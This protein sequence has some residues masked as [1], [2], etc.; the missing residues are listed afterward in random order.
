MHGSNGCGNTE[1][2]KTNSEDCGKS[3]QNTTKPKG[4]YASFLLI[5][6]AVAIGIIMI[7]WYMVVS[8]QVKQQ[9]ENS[10]IVK[11]AKF[12]RIPVAKV[13]KA[14]V[15][16]SDYVKDKNTLA[17]F[18]NNSPEALPP[19]VGTQLS[20]MVISRLVATK[21]IYQIAQDNAITVSEEEKEEKRKEVFA[22]F[23]S[24]EEAKK[25]VQEKY[26]ISF[27]TYFAD[28]VTP[29]ILE[30]KIRLAI[31]D[32]S[33]SV[34]EQFAQ[35]QRKAR[36]ILFRVN[37]E[38]TDDQA[39]TQAEQVQKKLADGEDFAELAKEF[40]GDSTKENGG[41]LGWFGRGTMVPEFE[42][43][44][45]ALEP[46]QVSEDLVKTQFGY[47]IVKLDDTRSIQDFAAYMESQ[48]ES[49]DIQFLV[50]INN[51]FNQVE[52]GAVINEGE[53]VQS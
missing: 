46:G 14:S 34:D 24:E 37:E 12:F 19:L 45:F 15:L 53:E 35:E 40:G 9:S 31:E 27:E 20:D 47:H 2:C 1:S 13:N 10:S 51:P 33:I 22:L 6:M 43:A 26:G 48:F 8:S 41:D 11:A 32:G 4:N 25:E 21:L 23:P 52:V 36:H 42:Q 17:Y 29:L 28:V 44:I 49:A 18:F 3:N 5:G 7:G 38:I 16:Y 39:K 50:P 30:E